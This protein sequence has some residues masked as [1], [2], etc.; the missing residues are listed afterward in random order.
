MSWRKLLENNNL[1]KKGISPQEVD[2]VLNKAY[3]CLQAAEILL[4][5]DIDESVFKEAY[6]AMILAS[7]S[8]MF[9]LGLKPRSVGAHTITINFCEEYLGKEF[10]ILV[11]KFRKMKQKR[12]YLIYGIGLVISKTEAENALKTAEEFIEKIKKVIQKKNPQK[13]LI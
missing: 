2:K 9:S 6:D 11:E 10:K 12:N 3:K 4:E 8:L 5:K 1:Q 7:R 13:K